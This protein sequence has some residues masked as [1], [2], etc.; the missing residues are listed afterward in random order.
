MTDRRNGDSNNGR[1]SLTTRALKTCNRV[2]V[3]QSLMELFS[4]RSQ[5][6]RHTKSRT[7]LV[8]RPS[9]WQS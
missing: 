1:L 3:C 8:M 2:R 4:V 9:H 7:R 5:L 6:D